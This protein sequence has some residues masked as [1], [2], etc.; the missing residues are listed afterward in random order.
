MTCK[1]FFETAEKIPKQIFLLFYYWRMFRGSWFCCFVVPRINRKAEMGSFIDL[2]NFFSET[3]QHF[4]ISRS[5]N[6]KYRLRSW[7]VWFEPFIIS[8]DV[9]R[10][11]F[12]GGVDD[13]T[14][15]FCTTSR[16][17]MLPLVKRSVFDVNYTMASW[18]TLSRKLDVLQGIIS[19]AENF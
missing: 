4:L 17:V 1:K 9:W 19:V 6:V 15:V 12:I 18:R 14:T 7:K 8:N 2:Y 16:L 5:S 3:W 13:V 11:K 10:Q